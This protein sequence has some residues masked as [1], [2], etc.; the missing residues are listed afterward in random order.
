[1]IWPVCSG[2]VLANVIGGLRPLDA[3]D[4]HEQRIADARHQLAMLARRKK[5]RDLAWPRDWRPHTVRDPS[6]GE[7]FTDAGAWEFIAD[8]LEAG[9]PLDEIALDNPPG[10]LGYVVQIDTDESTPRIYIKVRLGAGKVLGV[11]FHYSIHS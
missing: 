7:Y 6:T 9:E 4:A 10:K 3:P 1:M 5:A 11:S 2:H 8:C